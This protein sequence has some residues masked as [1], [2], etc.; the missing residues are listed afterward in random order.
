MG[1]KGQLS[2]TEESH[3]PHRDTA[4]SRGKIVIHPLSMGCAQK[5]SSRVNM[6]QGGGQSN[7]TVEKS[8]TKSFL[9]PFVIGIKA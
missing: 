2:L 5:P 8:V 6:E 1:E 7:F 9:S 4:P 3:V